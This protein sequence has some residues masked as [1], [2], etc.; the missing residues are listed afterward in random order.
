[1][2]ILYIIKMVMNLKTL[3]VKYIKLRDKLNN[4]KI[5][6]IVDNTNDNVYIGSTCCSLKTRLAVHKCDYD[7]FLKGLY[8]NITSFDILKNNNFKIQLLENCNIKTKKELLARERFYIENNNCVNKVIPCRS[9]K[10]YRDDNK[11]HLKEQE[12]IYRVA[13]KDKIKEKAKNYYIDNQDKIKIYR[14]NNKE[15]LKEQYKVYSVKNKEKIDNYQKAYRIT[16]RDKIREHKNQKY[17]CQCGGQYT[18]DHK[19]RHLRTDRHRKYLETI[20]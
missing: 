6:K 19:A 15:H 16:N 10:E 13:N 1:M 18:H 11:E 2:I 14:D 3:F 9:K 5:Y 20:S 12:K 8:H 7:R 4:G 17:D